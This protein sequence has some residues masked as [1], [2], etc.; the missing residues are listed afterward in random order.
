[1]PSRDC[2]EFSRTLE[3]LP[4]LGWIW[5]TRASSARTLRVATI[6][7]REDSRSSSNTPRATPVAGCSLCRR[8]SLPPPAGL[9]RGSVPTKRLG[10]LT[11]QRVRITVFSDTGLHPLRELSPAGCYPGS[12]TIAIRHIHPAVV[13]H[14][15]EEERSA[16]PPP[17]AQG[18]DSVGPGAPTRPTSGFAPW[19][20]TPYEPRRGKRRLRSVGTADDAVPRPSHPVVLTAILVIWPD[21]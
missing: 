16:R 1:M 8:A 3:P 14:A 21:K 6:Q 2:Q 13:W 5:A 10:K 20:L 18:S 7:S 17:L 9:H 12:R 11:L 19:T 4:P 15:I